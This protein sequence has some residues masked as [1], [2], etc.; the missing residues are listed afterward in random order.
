MRFTN[1]LTALAATG[2][3]SAR[4]ERRQVPAEPTGVTTITSPSGAEIR[5]KQ[6][7]RDGVLFFWFFEAR[8]NAATAPLTLWLN[9]GPGSD[10]LIGLFQ[11][12]GPCNVTANLTT[13]VN[14]Y[15][16]S[17]VSNMLFLSQ[18]IGVGFSYATEEVVDY[19]STSGEYTNATG[20]ADANGRISQ[21]DPY[22][23]DTTYLSATGTWEILQGFLANLDTLD[24]TVQNKTFNLWTES[25]GGH[26]GPAFYEYFSEQNNMIKNG[27]AN[28]TC[29]YMDT[30]GIGNGIIDELI[31]APYYPEFT[32]HNTYGIQLVNESIYN[33]MKWAYYIGGG[34]RDQVLECA[35][36][37]QSTAAGKAVCSQATDFCRGFVEEPY[38][39][40]GSRG[41]YDIR[42]PYDDPTPPTYFID[43]LNTAAVQNALGVDLN[44]T[45]D[46]SNQVGKGFSST[47][48][49]VYSSLIADLETILNNGVR[50]ALYYGDAD[51]ICNWFGGQAVSLQVNYTHATE[52]RASDYS[53]FMVDG[54]EYG[55]V[56]QYGNF[57]FLRVYESGHEVPFYQ[58]KASLEMF[59]RVLGNL[60]L[61][62]G[63]EAVT[64]NYS[65]PG[66]ASATHTEPF[67]P[68]PTSSGAAS[69]GAAGA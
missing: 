22:R 5:Y 21:T 12:L 59:R 25:Y 67:V 45:A 36:V 4:P 16:W 31:Q 63:S 18:P 39:E 54:V 66:I 41:V 9:G 19:N 7:G 10:S 42:H 47:G 27:T 48:D 60:V 51:Y 44:Y 14:P 52:F 28:G 40:Y 17:N 53:P 64:K 65:S 46:S 37:D 56:R 1:T 20:K 57:S 62:D 43:Y 35:E 49:F 61:A 68:L 8:E 69:S 30:L 2:C 38:Y 15:S 50:V 29:L 11:E 26:Y 55:E 6:P 33:F 3:A 24:N 13:E 32:Q 34:C 58:P 23:Y